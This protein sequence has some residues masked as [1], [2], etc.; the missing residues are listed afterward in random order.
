MHVPEEVPWRIRLRFG[1]AALGGASTC[2]GPAGCSASEANVFKIAACKR[3]LPG[4]GIE[5]MGRKVDVRKKY[6][7]AYVEVAASLPAFC[8]NT[9]PAFRVQ[10]TQRGGASYKVFQ[11]EL[12]FGGRW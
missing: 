5:V 12:H 9:K 6:R 11:A 10:V 1:Y 7:E 4:V 2:G 8:E 3:G